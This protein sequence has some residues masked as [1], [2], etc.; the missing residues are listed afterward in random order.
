MPDRAFIIR[1]AQIALPEIA[2]MNRIALP[3][4]AALGCVA[5]PSPAGLPPR[6]AFDIAALDD[7]EPGFAAAALDD[8]EL[9]GMVGTGSGLDED[10]AAILSAQRNFDR[11]MLAASTSDPID[12]WWAQVGSEL[13]AA[14]L[15]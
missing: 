15:L 2:A 9:A 11:S 4:L 5:V 8:R 6:L 12:T 7:R 1:L 14:N 13:I 3:L 10:M